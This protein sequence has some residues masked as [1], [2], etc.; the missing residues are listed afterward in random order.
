[1]PRPYHV[2][3]SNTAEVLQILQRPAEY[4]ENEDDVFYVKKGK[5]RFILGG[6]P[7][8]PIA[9]KDN[10]TWICPASAI[11]GGKEFVLEEG[12]VAIIP[13][14]NWHSWTAPDEGSTI[15]VVTKVPAAEGRIAYKTRG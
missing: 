5:M 7:E 1:M 12:D 14:G 6:E 10:L 4:H 11:V 8:G 13:A 9:T 15:Y 3:K 2:L